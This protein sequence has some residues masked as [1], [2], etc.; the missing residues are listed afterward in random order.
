VPGV[1]KGTQAG[2]AGSNRELAMKIGVIAK[3]VLWGVVAVLAFGA[4][5]FSWHFGWHRSSQE[6][7][8]VMLQ[9]YDVPPEIAE[10]VRAALASALSTRDKNAAPLGQV[11]AL[12][13]GQLLVTAPASVQ[14]GVKR[15]LL[16]ISERKPG[17]TP[18]IGFDVWVVKATAAS[19]TSPSGALTEI[20]PALAVIRKSQGSRNFEVLEKLSTQARPGR[21]ASNVSGAMM[22]AEIRA[23]LRKIDATQSLVAA[24]INVSVS[25]SAGSHA[26]LEAQAELRPGEL[27]VIG[28]SAL[29]GRDAS[30]AQIYYIVR[31]TL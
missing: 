25:P 15:L 22:Q 10:E 14:A 19:A 16:D 7:E 8:P 27:L 26:H 12:P 20:E 31:A 28:Q 17:P 30:K 3:W 23:T 1:I 11:S 18:T 4:L 13:N 6:N 9:G 24:K 21:E 29:P 5:N 2:A